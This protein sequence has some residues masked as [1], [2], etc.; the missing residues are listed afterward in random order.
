MSPVKDGCQT[1]Q[2]KD[3]LA[4]AVDGMGCRI[5]ES[6][7]EPKP[8]AGF[9]SNRTHPSSPGD[10][11]AESFVPGGASDWLLKQLI[12]TSRV[13]S[14]RGGTQYGQRC[15]RALAG[16]L[17]RRLFGHTCTEAEALE[18]GSEAE[19]EMRC[20]RFGRRLGLATGRQK[21]L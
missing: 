14:G 1:D 8:S 5:R 21:L 2:A 20:G 3:V 12:F 9:E 19:E 16:R 13:G 18:Q 15:Q 10:M 6:S 7:R 11:D 17:R 4:H